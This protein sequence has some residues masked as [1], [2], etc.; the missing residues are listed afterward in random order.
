[1]V[2]SA[3]LKTFFSGVIIFEAAMALDV[4]KLFF[5]NQ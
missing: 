1:M 3:K 5:F 2:C 4:S